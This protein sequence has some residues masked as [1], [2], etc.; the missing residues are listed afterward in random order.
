MHVSPRP[1]ARTWEG[2]PRGLGLQA[3][4]ARVNGLAATH[5]NGNAHWGRPDP[6]GVER[7]GTGPLSPG[8]SARAP[9][10]TRTLGQA[11]V[12]LDRAE[13][14]QPMGLETAAGCPAEVHQDF[15]EA[16][17]RSPIPS[18]VFLHS[19]GGVTGLG[20]KGLRTQLRN[21]SFG[22]LALINGHP[23]AKR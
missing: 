5:R 14:Q 12:W 7:L 18:L 2:L 20:A 1:C 19:S 21:E 10:L 16:L 13:T 23:P 4:G 8:D 9:V 15:W 6:E 17:P 3:V 22:P 11:S